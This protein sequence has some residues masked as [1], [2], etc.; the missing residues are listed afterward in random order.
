MR[1]LGALL[2]VLFALA[3]AVG[4]AGTAAMLYLVWQLGHLLMR[5]LEAWL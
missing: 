2:W 1:A 4:L 3:F 5:I